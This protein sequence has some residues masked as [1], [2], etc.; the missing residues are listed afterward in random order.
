MEEYFNHVEWNFINMNSPADLFCHYREDGTIY[1]EE[2]D[3][4][5]NGHLLL[6]S[7][8][9][10][11]A[12][13]GFETEILEIQDGAG[14][15]L[16]FGD[17]CFDRYILAVVGNGRLEVRIPNGVPLGDTFRYDGPRRPRTYPLA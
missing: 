3:R 9:A 7:F 4:C 2:Y 16:Y 13:C 15:G 12:S 14:I 1:L 6:S 10:D 17:G 5:R 8:F 11:A